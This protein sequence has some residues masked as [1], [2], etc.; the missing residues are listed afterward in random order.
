MGKFNIIFVL[1]FWNMKNIH[2]TE[3][4]LR[5]TFTEFLKKQ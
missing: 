3:G 2:E 5:S 4:I 1:V